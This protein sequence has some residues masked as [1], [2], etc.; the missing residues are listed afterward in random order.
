[1]IATLRERGTTVLTIGSGSIDTGVF[2]LRHPVTQAIAAITAFYGQ[3]H[4]L[5]VS[6]GL[7]PDAP[8]HLV[9]ATLTE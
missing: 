3:V 4:E 2:G 7:N 6:L 8:P 9:K 5:S 1:M